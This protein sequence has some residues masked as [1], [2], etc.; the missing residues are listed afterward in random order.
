MQG[1]IEATLRKLQ[2]AVQEV[3]PQVQTRQLRREGVLS[4]SRKRL[5]QVEAPDRDTTSLQWNT[6]ALAEAGIMR[7]EVNAAYDR[8]A[9]DRAAPSVAWSS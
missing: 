7:A 3:A 4:A 2:R 8:Q 5:I 1:R 9:P 6:D